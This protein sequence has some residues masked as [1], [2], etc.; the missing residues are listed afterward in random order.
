MD[1]ELLA[2]QA[3]LVEVMLARE[4]ERLLDLAA[5]DLDRCGAGVLLDDREDVRQQAALERGQVGARDGG[6]VCGRDLI[7]GRA[8]RG[9]DALTRRCPYAAFAVTPVRY[10][11]PSSYRRW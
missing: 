2:G 11:R 5:V 9:P 8:L 4:D 3:S 6:G 10:L 7:D 1:D